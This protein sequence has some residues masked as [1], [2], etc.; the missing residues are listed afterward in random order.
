M[1]VPR[2]MTLTAMLTP[3]LCLSPYRP[4]KTVPLFP[5]SPIPPMRLLTPRRKPV[6]LS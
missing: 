3:R 2:G 4:P 1:R 6:V 5:L